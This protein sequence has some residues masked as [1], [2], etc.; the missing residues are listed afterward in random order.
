VAVKIIPKYRD[1]IHTTFSGSL[2]SVKKL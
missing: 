1:S 2:F